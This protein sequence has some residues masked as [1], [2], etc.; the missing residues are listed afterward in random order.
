MSFS[1]TFEALSPDRVVVR[2]V[3]EL[4]LGTAPAFEAIIRQAMHAGLKL[5]VADLSGLTYIN[6]HGMYGLLKAHF[7]LSREGGEVVI[8]GARPE[9]RSALEL[10]GVPV[11]IRC[12]PALAD[13]LIPASRVAGSC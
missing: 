6:S 10:L 13:A 7:Q 1:V 11:R 5:L 3:G 9:V 8:V 2:A 4:D 12:L